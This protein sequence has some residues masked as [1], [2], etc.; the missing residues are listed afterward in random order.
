MRER[1]KVGKIEKQP[2]VMKKKNKIISRF[3][4]A[5]TQIATILKSF[6]LQLILILNAHTA[7][8]LTVWIV[9]LIIMTIR[10]AKS[11]KILSVHLLK[12][13]LFKKL[14]LSRTSKFASAIVV[15]FY[16]ENRAKQL[17]LALTRLARQYSTTM[18]EKLNDL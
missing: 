12:S 17:Q 4:G 11:I 18:M 5:L 7:N 3:N 6:Q 9:E 15:L 1:G 16:K 14:D 13:P 10:P 8:F 2:K